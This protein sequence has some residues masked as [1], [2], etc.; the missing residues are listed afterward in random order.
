[1][2]TRPTISPGDG[3]PRHGTD[4]GYVNLRCRCDSCRQAHTEAV[5]EYRSSVDVRRR[6]NRLDRERRAKLR[7]QRPPKPPPEPKPPKRKLKHHATYAG[8][9]RTVAAG[10]EPSETQK[11]A[12]RRYWRAQRQR[13]KQRK[14]EA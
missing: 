13:R 6:R 9:A 4:N 2:A 10:K 7:E 11:E 5:A 3:D 1:M 14:E 12:A 8:W